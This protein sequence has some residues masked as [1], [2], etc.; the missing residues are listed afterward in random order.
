MTASVHPRIAVPATVNTVALI[1]P[2]LASCT[3]SIFSL[4][5]ISLKKNGTWTFSTY[6]QSMLHTGITFAPTSND[7][8]ITTLTRNPMLSF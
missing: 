6:P 2:E 5:I 7:N 1:D 8:A 3:K 4:S